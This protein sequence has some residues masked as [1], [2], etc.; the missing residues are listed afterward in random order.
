[1]KVTSSTNDVYVQV[2]QQTAVSITQLHGSS[3]DV[4]YRSHI[5]CR[6]YAIF[7]AWNSRPENVRLHFT[8]V[9]PLSTPIGC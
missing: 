2:L 9:A 1:M 4:H 7:S 3:T 6:V 5:V 8:V